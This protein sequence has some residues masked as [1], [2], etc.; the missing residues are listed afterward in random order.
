MCQY[1]YEYEGH[2]SY[3]DNIPGYAQGAYFPGDEPGTRCRLTGEACGNPHGDEPTECADNSPTEWLCPECQK[4]GSDVSLW[5]SGKSGRF[6]CR[7]CEGEWSEA[8]LPRAFTAL[9]IHLAHEQA[10]TE[11]QRRQAQE[12]KSRLH[13]VL[14]KVREA[15][16]LAV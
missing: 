12:E 3:G 5:K 11:E 1:S 4:E 6:F 13:D 10:D 15:L 8:E 7:E 2:H 14:G 16:G 9:L